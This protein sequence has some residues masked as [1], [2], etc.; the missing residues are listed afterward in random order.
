MLS[1]QERIWELGW[2]VLVR[3]PSLEAPETQTVLHWLAAQFRQVRSKVTKAAFD[4]L[5]RT[6][7]VHDSPGASNASEHNTALALVHRFVVLCMDTINAVRLLDHVAANADRCTEHE[8]ASAERAAD[9]VFRA[10]R[11]GRADE[12]R[13]RDGYR[14]ELQ[15]ASSSGGRGDVATTAQGANLPGLAPSQTRTRCWPNPAAALL[16]LELLLES[17]GELRAPLVGLVDWTAVV[18]GHHFDL[19]ID[20]PE[21]SPSPESSEGL[22]EALSAPPPL[23]EIALRPGP[24]NE[25]GLRLRPSAPRAWPEAL[26][27]ALPEAAGGLGGGF[28][29][30]RSP[31]LATYQLHLVADLDPWLTGKAG[32]GWA[33]K[34]HRLF[35][36]PV[37]QVV[38][39]CLLAQARAST[40]L[41]QEQEQEREKAGA[42]PARATAAR[43]RVPLAMAK[44][45]TTVWFEVW[46]FFDF[47]D[48][49][50]YRARG[51][52][53][54][55]A[56][57]AAALS[58]TAIA[59]LGLGL[60]VGLDFGFDV[61][62][63]LE[64]RAIGVEPHSARGLETDEPPEIEID[65][66]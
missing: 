33:P 19:Q 65:Q 30:R 40:M 38:S 37:R 41:L 60:G 25:A 6:L 28:A 45:P 43:P 21:A 59:A 9:R 13:G 12:D 8:R 22:D 51:S 18:L 63:L 58:A 42:S 39:T 49:S 36:D 27:E 35:P 11:L 57:D 7:F 26:P 31:A 64:M 16:V 29:V 34:F 3:S 50:E 61:L 55:T 46:S 24:L 1:V 52:A 62:G 17:L 2:V 23:S 20:G 48:F 4:E 10:V 32:L 5:V 44:V 56:D 47:R 66:E 14:C 54:P 15:W 53:Q